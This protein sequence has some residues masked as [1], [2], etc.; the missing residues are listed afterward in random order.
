AQEWDDR[1]TGRTVAVLGAGIMG[2][3]IAYASAL[4]GF[5]TL[6]QD[7]SGEALEKAMA[8]ISAILERG[9][10]TGKVPDH[11]AADAH[12]RLS[13]VRRLEEATREAD[14]VIEAVP[15][16]IDLKVDIFSTGHRHAG[17]QAILA[18]NTA[19]LSISVVADPSR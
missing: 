2:R 1:M 14:L 15:A 6:L 19:A 18:S 16:D 7:T 5:T 13:G 8:E 10:A 11:A 12:R 9:A 3:G 17:P 4:G